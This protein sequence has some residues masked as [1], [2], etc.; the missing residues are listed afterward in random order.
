MFS[1]NAHFNTYNHGTES[2][3]L[4]QNKLVLAKNTKNI[5]SLENQFDI[6]MQQIKEKKA[7][8]K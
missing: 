3:L 1:R 6:I 2:S 4:K 7:K 8:I 5:N